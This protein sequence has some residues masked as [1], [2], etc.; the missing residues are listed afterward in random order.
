MRVSRCGAR[1]GHAEARKPKTYKPPYKNGPS[2]G[3]EFN[4]VHRDPETGQI[5]VVRAFPGVPPVVGCAPEPSAGWGMFKVEHRVTE[6]RQVPC[7]RRSTGHSIRT[8]WV[9]V[10]A[11]VGW[12]W[13]GGQEVPGP[14]RRRQ[15]RDR[16]ALQASRRRGTHHD[17]VRAPARRCMSAGR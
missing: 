17:R 7:R 13:L 9:T 5:A 1:A 10:G 6:A 15:D 3:D 11:T 16:Q 2:G 12:T 14:S 4:Y 8:S